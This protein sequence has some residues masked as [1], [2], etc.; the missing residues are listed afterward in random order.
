MMSWLRVL[1]YGSKALL[2]C[3]QRQRDL[4]IPAHDCQFSCIIFFGEMYITISFTFN[5]H[6][7]AFAEQA[8]GVPA[9]RTQPAV[10]YWLTA[11]SNRNVSPTE[12]AA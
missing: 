10:E 5:T 4:D 7:R 8:S 11:P 12:C 2:V 3:S 1:C 6:R 9:D